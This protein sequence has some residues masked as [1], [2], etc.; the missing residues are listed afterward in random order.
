ML[1][2]EIALLVLGVILL[3]VGYRKN[4]R[5][6]LVLSALVLLVSAC[7]YQFA[8]GFKDGFTL[9]SVV[10]AE[11][12]PNKACYVARWCHHLL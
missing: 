1:Y 6:I 10:H 5:N 4:N 2:V 7:I 8:L 12:A 9:P 3:V 11:A